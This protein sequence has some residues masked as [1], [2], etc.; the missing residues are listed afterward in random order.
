M[1]NITKLERPSVIWVCECGCSSFNIREDG[2][3]ECCVCSQLADADGQGWYDRT[4]DGHQRSDDLDGP[5]EDTSGNGSMEFVRRR[6]A[7]L[8]TDETAVLLVVAREDGSV[9]AWSVAETEDQIDWVSEKLEAAMRLVQSNA[10]A[11]QNAK[12]T[13][14]QG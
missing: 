10:T 13:P 8:A 1:G 14:S 9:S 6:V 3:A 11:T 4:K 2:E 7:Q 5:I 12:P